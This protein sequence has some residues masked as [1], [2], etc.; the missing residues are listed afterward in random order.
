MRNTKQ[1]IFLGVAALLTG[2]CGSAM[3]AEPAR[4]WGWKVYAPPGP[5]GPGGPT[6]PSGPAGLAG[7][8]GPPGPPGSE[9]AQAMVREVPVPVVKEVEKEVV[10]EVP[11]VKEVVRT[12]TKELP[13]FSN[14]IFD[15]DQATVRPSES[16]KIKAVADFLQKNPR[17]EIGLLGHT[18]PR[19]TDPYNVKLSEQRTKAVSD[20]LVEAGV[21]RDR[22]RTVAMGKRGRNCAD[23][24]ENCFGQNR[25]VEFFF[26]PVGQ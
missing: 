24:T 3:T 18:D 17:L 20:A 21:P 2:A 12:E 16:D 4:D 8:A 25:R 23:D 6:G 26:R 10:R 9:G 15:F 13:P 19:G 22:L 11:V 14:I 5:M 7:P 1:L